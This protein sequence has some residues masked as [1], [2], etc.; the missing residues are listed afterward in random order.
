MRIKTLFLASMMAACTAG[1][2]PERPSEAAAAPE[3]PAEAAAIPAP[4]PPDVSIRISAAQDGQTVQ[5]PVGERFAVSL[6]G[7][8]TAGYVWEPVE[9]P[10]FVERLGSAIGPIRPEQNQPGFTGGSHWEVLTFRV[11]RAGR[12]ELKLE[13]RRPWETGQPPAHTFRVTIASQ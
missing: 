7:I 6:I 9:I 2:A 8:P 11:T 1:A 10:G 3:S 4:V 12:G 13:Q 5:A